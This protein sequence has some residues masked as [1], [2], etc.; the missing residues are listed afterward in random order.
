MRFVHVDKLIPYQRLVDDLRLELTDT[1]LPLSIEVRI[2]RH[3]GD[4]VE[5]RGEE[6]REEE[7]RQD[8]DHHVA[9]EEPPAD[10][11]EELA[12]DPSRRDGQAVERERDDEQPRQEREER[13][14]GR[15]DVKAVEQVPDLIEG[16]DR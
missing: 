9:E 2:T 10:G 5:N 6:N 16:D 14:R 15:A 8:A 3:A 7:E 13:D 12:E 1:H 11:P 4:H